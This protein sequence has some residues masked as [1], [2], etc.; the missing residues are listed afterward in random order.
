MRKCNVLFGRSKVY[1]LY[2]KRS[3]G[4]GQLD[5]FTL[6]DVTKI[7]GNVGFEYLII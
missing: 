4:N 7:N 1:K 6:H 2:D 3:G 5:A